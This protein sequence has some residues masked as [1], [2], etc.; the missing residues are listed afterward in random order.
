MERN[1]GGQPANQNARTHGFY[2]KVLLGTQKQDFE[3]ATHVEGLDEEIALLRVRIKA[4]IE[5]DS[6]NAELIERAVKTLARLV[7]ARYAHRMSET[8]SLKEAVRSVIGDAILSGHIPRET[9]LKS[10][11]IDEAALAGLGYAERIEPPG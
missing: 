1:R 11:N 6:E 10:L 5:H 4:L 2:S 7:I 8:G 3:E 9:L